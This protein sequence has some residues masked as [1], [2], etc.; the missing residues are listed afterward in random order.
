M[1]HGKTHLLLALLLFFALS[2]TPAAIAQTTAQTDFDRLFSAAQN[3]AGDASFLGLVG[4]NIS[5]GDGTADSW[6]YLMQSTRESRLFG[7]V[8]SNDGISSPLNLAEF[9]PELTEMFQPGPINARWLDSDIAIS[10]AEENGGA[11]FRGTY[12][13]ARISAALI[14]IPS[15]E[16]LDLELPPIPALWIISYN[17]LSEDAFASSIHVVDATFG[18]HI[19]IDPSTAGSNLEAAQAAAADFAED[20]ELVTVSTL[21]PDF[22]PAGT[23]AVWQF[24]YYSASLDAAQVIYLAGGLALASTPTLVDPV[25]TTPLP[26]NWFDS[27]FAAE[28]AS[29]SDLIGDV[30]ISPS[31]VQARLSR[32]LL[33][34]NAEAAFWQINYLLIAEDFLDNLVEDMDLEGISVESLY[35]EAED[36]TPVVVESPFVLIDATT[37]QPVDGFNPI[38]QDA[39]LDLATLPGA[40]NISVQFENTVD[41]VIFTLNGDVVNTESLPPYALFGDNQ[42]DFNAGNLPIQKHTLTATPIVDGTPGQSATVNFEVVNSLLPSVSG[43]IFIDAATDEE[44]FEL[45]DGAVFQVG[46]LPEQLNLAAPAGSQVKSVLFEINDG[47][48]KRLE[49]VAPFA[50]FG[51]I[52]GDFLPSAFPPGGYTLTATPFSEV[53][54]GGQQ[55]PVT[56]IRFTVLNSTTAKNGMPEGYF[57]EPLNGLQADVPGSF[58]LNDNY[59][60]PFNP[61]TTISFDVP[62]TSYVQLDVYDAL[63]RYIATL[64]DA[65]FETGSHAIQFDARNLTSGMYFYRLITPENTITKKMLLLK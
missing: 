7:Y 64:A 11:A 22:S 23:A 62:S 38:A 20:A 57:I 4:D 15:T 16:L 55:G 43:L 13:N 24:T 1:I 27:P 32:G 42:G 47:L 9:P 29:V 25:S 36:I 31:L 12:D 63:G 48:Y 61:V 35:I 65:T 10:I 49:N 45:T 8:R 52:N 2:F 26:E 40:L 50:L 17:S 19:Q 60:N 33:T 54:M 44:A 58:V 41:Q 53:M 37:D 56:S 3:E 34:E 46:E 51:D 30:V 28:E 5:P 18:L 21:L 6:F 59:P 39:K 14:G